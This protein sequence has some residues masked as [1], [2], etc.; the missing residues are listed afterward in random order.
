MHWAEFDGV[1]FVEG[2]LPNAKVICRIDHKIHGVF[3]QAQLKNLND[4]KRKMARA[5]KDR[6]GNALLNFEYGQKSSFWTTLVGVDNVNWYGE[7][8][9]AV[10][11][12]NDIAILR[13]G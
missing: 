5:V 11:S 1:F 2:T 8:D 9:V 4:V 7:G 13:Q 6:G 10:I 12:A 3:S